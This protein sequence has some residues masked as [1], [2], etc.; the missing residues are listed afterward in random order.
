MSSSHCA[1]MGGEESLLLRRITR[2]ARREA[3]D[4]VRHVY[5]V[6]SSQS[7]RAREAGVRIQEM[8]ELTDYHLT[9]APLLPSQQLVCQQNIRPARGTFTFLPFQAI[10]VIQASVN[11]GEGQPCLQDSE[12]AK[13][14]NGEISKQNVFKNSAVGLGNLP[15]CI[16]EM[17]KA[18]SAWDIGSSHLLSIMNVWEY[19]GLLKIAL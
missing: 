5:L 12:R 1:C 7:N 19:Q 18:I 2:Q 17:A 6:Y 9:V 13:H 8:Q 10:T 16:E 14:N 4:K 3:K 15:D 11:D